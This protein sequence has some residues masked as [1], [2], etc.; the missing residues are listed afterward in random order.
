MRRK[1]MR[2]NFDIFWKMRKIATAKSHAGK[3]HTNWV[4]DTLW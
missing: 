2:L 4:I 1:K 3:L